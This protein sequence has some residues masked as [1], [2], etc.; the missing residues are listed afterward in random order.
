MPYDVEYEFT[1]PIIIIEEILENYLG[2][3]L[4]ETIQKDPIIFKRILLDYLI[5]KY[6]NIFENI[7]EEK[8]NNILSTLKYRKNRKYLYIYVTI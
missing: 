5:N 4:E 1:I 6:P 2:Y 7:D 8:Y 3:N